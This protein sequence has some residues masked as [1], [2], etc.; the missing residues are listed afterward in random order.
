M[1]KASGAF[2][3]AIKDAE[4]LL[5]HYSTLHPGDGHPPPDI[6]VIKRAGLV[7]AMMAWET[8]VEDRLV[9]ALEHR[10]AHLNDPTVADLVRKKLEVEIGRLHNPNSDRT[11]DLFREYAGVELA[12][13]WRWA[14]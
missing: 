8:Y 12:D 14:G 1:S 3:H 10:L 6:E 2:E 5:K 4:N 13:K 9:E 7:M 11:F